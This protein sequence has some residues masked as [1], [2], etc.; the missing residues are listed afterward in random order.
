MFMGMLQ[1]RR[2][3][4]RNT[5]RLGY[6]QPAFL[7]LVRLQGNAFHVF[8][9]DIVDA[10]LLADVENIDDRRVDEPGRR[11]CFPL[12]LSQLALVLQELVL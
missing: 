9:D 1:R 8:H 7:L 5:D 12:K 4:R 10:V 6:F 3:L 11:F 2:Q